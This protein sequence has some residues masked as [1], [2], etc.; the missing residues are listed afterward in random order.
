MN[1]LSKS[2]SVEKKTVYRI[3]C[4]ICG[5]PYQGNWADSPG[6]AKALAMERGFALTKDKK[7]LYCESCTKE[8]MP[9][10]F[11]E[12]LFCSIF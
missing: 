7:L 5:Y 3:R 12:C 10:V 4:C 9:D 2:S 6:M 1:N 11:I 8:H